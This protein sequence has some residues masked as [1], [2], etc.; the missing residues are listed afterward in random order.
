MSRNSLLSLFLLAIMTALA[1]GIYTSY[2]TPTAVTNTS[3]P[4][5]ASSASGAFVRPSRTLQ[6]VIL[7]GRRGIIK[8]IQ[9]DVVLITPTDAYT[10]PQE[11]LLIRIVPETRFVLV[12]IPKE[13]S[14]TQGAV[15]RS[16]L[17]R[18]TLYSGDDVFVI[19]FHN[20]AASTT[21]SALRIEKIITP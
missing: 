17:D 14:P 11:E 7:R 19:S 2:R 1:Y 21:F 20:I 12:S 13:P 16:V 4:P 5:L 3:S 8:H 6:E 10:R 15:Q 18:R 9:A